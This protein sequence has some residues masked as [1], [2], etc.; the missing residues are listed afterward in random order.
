MQHHHRFT[1]HEHMTVAACLRVMEA[2][3][4]EAWHE[5]ENIFALEPSFGGVELVSFPADGHGLR[6]YLESMQ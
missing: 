4:L 6:A 3:G 5:G 1:P 2:L